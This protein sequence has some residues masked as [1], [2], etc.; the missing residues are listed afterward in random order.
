MGLSRK[1]ARNITQGPT[2]ADVALPPVLPY[3]D[4]WSAVAFS[5]ELKPGAVLTRPLQ[6]EDV[7]LYRLRDG[8]LRA[9][10]PY[11]PHLGAHL[12]LGAVEGDD[13]VCVFHRFAFGPDGSCVRTGYGAPPP[14]AA[15]AQL[16]VRE[17]NDA[18][19]VW[20]HHD[21]RAPDWEI[22]V[23]HG[24]DDQ[25]LRSTTWELA[26]HAQEVMENAVDLGH[27]APCTAAPGRSWRPRSSST[28]RRSGSR[29]GSG[30]R[31]RSSA[32]C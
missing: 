22:P 4:G 24:L 30:R 19:F 2:P 21:G 9:V 32:S 25:P 3:P 17:V 13:L 18:V 7:V 15:L 31:S 11:C 29:C 8:R 26:G 27:F 12:G 6:G 5:D 14:R 20:R 28:G 16:P 23:F 1:Y 10:R